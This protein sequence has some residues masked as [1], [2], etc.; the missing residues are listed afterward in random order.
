MHTRTHIHQ[1]LVVDCG[2]RARR[3]AGRMKI[4]RAK[5][6]VARLERLDGLQVRGRLNHSLNL[7]T[8]TFANDS[9]LYGQHLGLPNVLG[10]K[11]AFTQVVN[12]HDV[13]VN[14]C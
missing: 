13:R 2:K 5:Q 6:N 9:I 7:H 8:G 10:N 12:F 1:N 11:I 4:G 3:Y 14:E